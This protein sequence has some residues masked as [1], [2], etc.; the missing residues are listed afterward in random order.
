[1]YLLT[2]PQIEY[3]KKGQ[4]S[5]TALNCSNQDNSLEFLLISIDA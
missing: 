1:M 3:I 4:S 2:N 5:L